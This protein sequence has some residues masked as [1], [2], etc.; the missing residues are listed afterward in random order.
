MEPSPHEEPKL[1][2]RWNPA[3]KIAFRFLFSYFALL[4]V[5]S[6]I[7]L[8]SW[9]L[10]L[11]RK[12]DALWHVIVFWLD[13][14]ILHTGYPLER[15]EA[16]EG[17]SNLPYGWLLF[18]CYVTLAAAGTVVWSVLDRR[19]AGYGRLHQ[20]FRLLLRY[21][22]ALSMINYGIIKLIPTQMIAPPPLFVL[23]H[24]I[25][26]LPPMRLL[27]IF[28]GSSP[29]Y[30]TF[31]GCAELLG[32]VLLLTPR[33]TLLGALIC[34]ADMVNVVM[35]NLCYDVHVKLISMQLLAM[36]VILVAPDLRR[37][38]GLLLFNRG[39]EPIES[40]PLSSRLWL[41]RTPQV[42][43]FLFGLY[44]IGNTFVTTYK[45]Y[46]TFHPPRPPLYGAWSV[47]QFA[48]DG[49]D[50]PLFTDPQR[51][52]WMVFQE[53]GSVVVERMIGSRKSYS[54]HLDPKKRAMVLDSKT[55]KE[56][57]R[58]ELSYAKPAADVLTL[59]GQLNGHRVHARL[60]KMTLIS[61]GFHWIFVPPKVG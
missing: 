23:M 58:A 38:A 44:T 2:A 16:F 26:D 3:T 60:H 32:G 33:T 27:W 1:A 39:V 50:M 54:L 29:A 11:A 25:G 10:F 48:V 42:L 12:Y 28:M 35:L 36:A 53:P 59:E 18:L 49:H 8:L 9:N 40:P 52:R 20:W 14:H 15:I 34:C 51:W 22:L 24:R 56:P 57:E 61:T 55:P 7:A 43:F 5:Q 47:E 31:T 17:V 21:M 6:L 30:E 19:R 41:N 46:Q 37:L 4:S 13:R 45:W